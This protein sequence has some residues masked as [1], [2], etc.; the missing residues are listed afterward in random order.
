MNDWEKSSMTTD[1]LTF[2]IVLILCVC[3][4]YSLCLVNFAAHSW[5]ATLRY[6]FKNASILR[7]AV[8][9]L[10]SKYQVDLFVSG[11]IHSSYR[12]FPVYNGSFTTDY[13]KR[14]GKIVN[15]VAGGPGAID[16]PME[17]SQEEGEAGK[18]LF[19]WGKSLFDGASGSGIRRWS[20]EGLGTW[21]GKQ[22]YEGVIPRLTGS[23]HFG[24]GREEV[25]KKDLEF[26]AYHSDEKMF[27]LLHILD[28]KT[29]KWEFIS[30]ISGQVLD[31]ITLTK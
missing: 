2:Q 27:G 22:L 7:E 13:A 21:V 19:S 23:P 4:L 12:T 5:T 28:D 24:P 20:W 17:K 29:L 31:S 25:S 1:G 18:S 16:R 3:L 8:E 30:G 15:I 11:H 9:D 10:L 26:V 6:I 14:D